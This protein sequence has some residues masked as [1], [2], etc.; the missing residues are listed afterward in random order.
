MKSV[1]LSLSLA[2]FTTSSLIGQ[3]LCD[4]G[5]FSITGQVV[6]ACGDPIS[7][8]S[9]TAVNP[10]EVFDTGVTDGFGFYTLCIDAGKSGVVS[11]TSPNDYL[12]GVST[13]DQVLIE[14]HILGVESFTSPLEQISAD[15][16]TT[17]SISALDNVELEKLIL[18][19][20]LQFQ[21]STSWKYISNLDSLTLDNAFEAEFTQSFES[22]NG[23]LFDRNF[24]GVKIGDVSSLGC[25][26]AVTSNTEVTTSFDIG[27]SPN[28]FEASTQISF[29]LSQTSNIRL[30][31]SDL[32]GREVSQN[33]AKYTAGE[34][35]VELSADIFTKRGVYLIT[36]SDGRSQ[37]TQRVIFD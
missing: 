35:S 2:I 36:I 37:M 29:T 1:L 25:G 6:D 31:V 7:N 13:F 23:D 32:L 5:Q 11:P 34:H 21:N 14:R 17:Q 10:A 12:N 19:E 3:S 18:Q 30:V 24:T 8:L 33:T 22:M 20:I 28:P 9:I 4:T 16:N 27:I 26:A 15:V